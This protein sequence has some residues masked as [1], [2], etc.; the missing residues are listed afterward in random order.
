MR[1]RSSL[2]VAV[3]LTGAMLIARPAS[4]QVQTGSTPRP[5]LQATVQKDSL[6]RDTPRGTVL[7][8]IDAARKEN[9]EAAP[10]YLNTSL[11]D[12][13]AADLAHKLFVVLDTRLPP[14]LNELS[15]QPEGSRANPLKPDQD[16]FGTIQTASGPLDLI[17]ERVNRGATGPVWLFSRQTL[18][19]IPEV[20]AEVDLVSLDRYLPSVLRRRIGGIRLFEWLALFLL[21]P[22][23][24]RATGA[25]DR[26]FRPV[27][28]RWR[29]RH[30]RTALDPAAS[31]MPGFVRL[32][33]IALGIR[34]LLVTLELPLRE[35]QFWTAI[36]AMFFMSAVTWAFLLLDG[37]V[38]RI[39]V[40]RSRAYGHAEAVALLR[41]VRRMADVLIVT[42][43]VLVTLNYFGFDPTA[44]LAGLGIGGIAVA[45]AA[46][47]TL[48]NVIGGLSLILDQAVRVGDFVKIGDM[49]GTV[50]AI[51]LRST[52]IRTMDRTILS[53]PNS[54]VANANIETLS[55]RDK[56]WFHHMLALRLETS[57]A[58]MRDTVDAI[59]GYLIR[60]PL[61]DGSE[62]V[63]VRFLRLSPSSLD[64]E[65]FAYLLVRD[66]EQ[67]LETQQELLLGILECVEDA[68]ALIA[69]PSQL[70]HLADAAPASIS[71]QHSHL[72]G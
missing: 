23:A 38:E 39:V 7:G 32:L 20:F 2:V 56:F 63:R 18:E 21:L 25:L 15:D 52:R 58:L 14:R 8:F 16:V 68:G 54:L 3:A 44:A 60:H 50:D 28:A 30:G 69:L 33:L 31:M 5:P 62:S 59:R 24:Y 55:V 10:L 40:A 45:L 27:V 4:T 46:Q 70:L 19:A 71:R 17:V 22:A 53:V 57:S 29:R 35:R 6:G 37:V 36:S 66:W 43:A 9:N 61:V 48:E 1:P 49:S 12:K 34:W 41:L 47:K 72:E 67:F 64:V 13:A 11:R 26:V 65:I 42:V 51:G